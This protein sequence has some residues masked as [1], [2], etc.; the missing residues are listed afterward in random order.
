MFTIDTTDLQDV[1]VTLIEN[2][3]TIV[4]VFAEGSNSR[5]CLVR[6]ANLNL[7]FPILRNSTQDSVSSVIPINE[8]QLLDST[9]FEISIS[10]YESDESY[11]NLSWNVTVTVTIPTS[12][13]QTTGMSYVIYVC[14]YILMYACMCMYV[15]I[16]V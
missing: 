15:C 4:C 14:I 11:G 16:Y 10:D 8:L 3:L 9:N 13:T 2:N 1:N 7:T 12:T 5:G 6:L